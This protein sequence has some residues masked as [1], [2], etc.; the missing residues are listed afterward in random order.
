[1][2]LTNYPFSNPK[3]HLYSKPAKGLQGCGLGYRFAFNGKERDNETYGEGNSY[4]FGARIYDSRLGRWLSMDPMQEKYISYSPYNYSINSPI[5]LGDPDGN[6]VKVKTIRYKM[7]NGEKVKLSF[8]K[9]LFIK[10]DIIERQV[11]IHNAKVIDLTG[12]QSAEEMQGFA[13][14][15]QEEV[16]QNWTTANDPKADENGYVT[17][18]K[19]QKVKVTTSFAEDVQ[20]AQSVNDIK[21]GDNVYALVYNNDPRNNNGSAAGTAMQGLSIA[22]FSISSLTTDGKPSDE[23]LITHETGHIGGL[24]DTQKKSDQNNKIMYNVGDGTATKP[25][26]DEYTK[27]FRGG[28]TGGIPQN[29]KN[30]ADLRPSK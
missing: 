6:Y 28:S 14:A 5:A 2:Y 1:M 8:I 13:K 7:V 23:A 22:Y 25:H 24:P 9:S 12:K 11:V 17:N 29:G 20:I 4:D 18:S 15:V 10:A 30:S 27:F 19:G 26:P 21:G 16:S 3:N